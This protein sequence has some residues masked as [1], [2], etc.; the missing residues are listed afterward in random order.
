MSDGLLTL[1]HVERAR[2]HFVNEGVLPGDGV[3]AHIVRSWGRSQE[4]G[5]GD[6][7]AGPV[8][9]SELADRRDASELLWRCAQPELD[10]LAEH[11]VPQGCVVILS[12]ASGLI[13][14]EAG[15]A[16]FLP[17]AERV[18]LLPGVDWSEAQR[19]TN[20]IGTALAERDAVLVLGP[21]HFLSQNTALG[22]AATPILDGRGDLVGVLDV[23]G[24]SMRVDA[25]ALG[26]VR[27]A[28]AQIEHRMMSRFDG[29]ELVHFHARPGLLGTAREGLL[30]IVD[31]RI[32]GLNRVAASMLGGGWAAWIG[33][34]VDNVFGPRWPHLLGRP[35]LVVA[36]NGEQWAV[37]IDARQ[38]SVRGRPVEAD[39]AVPVRPAPRLTPRPAHDPLQALFARAT[40]VLDAGLPVLVTGET[41]TGKDWFSQRLHG[42]CRR[43]KG[44]FVGVNCAA[45]PETLIE[46]ELF[47]YEEGAFTGARRRGMPGRLREAHGGVL[48]L[49]EIGDMPLALQT[50]LLRVLEERRVRPL[51]SSHEVEVAFSL[52]CATH[53]DLFALVRE[54]RFREDLLYRLNGFLVELPALRER[55]DRRDLILQLF[56]QAGGSRRGL[57]LSAAALDALDAREWRGNVRELLSVLGAVVALADDG[58]VIQAADLP[59]STHGATHLALPQGAREAAASSLA[60]L[61]Q[62][63]VQAALARA[64]GRVAEAARAL[65]V[66]R[67][68]V[69]RWM[70][71]AATDAA[72]C[73]ANVSS[74]SL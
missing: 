22:C 51:G 16:E 50:R 71:A 1:A 25:H 56:E 44:P 45:L 63:A 21:E 64:G 49:D 32:V 23:S 18:A 70:R 60:E 14:D 48:F 15:S 36:P 72:R 13:L 62:Q 11:V 30:S 17:K 2:L 40:R 19:G 38:R 58:V 42:A 35:G 9:R 67:S 69:Y 39:T 59:A 6:R 8:S 26:L 3:A 7:R 12:D 4:L 52:V 34:P 27:M 20:A 37:A 65:G 68:T 46:A 54:G 53:R 66:H 5:A 61:E 41:G 74:S 28:A 43:A 57:S 33:S 47:G 55:A 31:G 24:E 29:G 73:D 10:A